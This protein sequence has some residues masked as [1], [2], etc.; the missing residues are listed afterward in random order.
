MA[1][2]AATPTSDAT[3]ASRP[4]SSSTDPAPG[5]GWRRAAQHRELPRALRTVIENVLKMMNAPTNSGD[6]GEGQQE[7]RR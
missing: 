6:A 1:M 4:A 3:T 5:A 7:V 2:P